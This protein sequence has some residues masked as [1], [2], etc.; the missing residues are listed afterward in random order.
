MAQPQNTNSVSLHNNNKAIQ[1]KKL[2]ESL[3]MELNNLP[4]EEE[5]GNIEYK[6][7]LINP[8]SSRL[9]HLVTQMKW[10]LQE[11]Q[12]EAIYKI[13]VEDNGICSGL[14]DSELEST[15][16]TL[17]SMSEKIGAD[18]T[19]LRKREVNSEAL[20]IRKQ[21]AEILV[22]KVPDDQ[23]F[24]DIRI[25]VLGNAD[26]GKSTLLGVL[27]HGEHD[28]GRG[29][30]RLNLFR[31]LHEIQ[32]GRTSC[33]SHE[34]L[35]FDSKGNVINYSESRTAEEICSA[36][37][38]IITFIDLAGHH[39][40]LKTT[41]FGL[42]SHHPDFAVVVVSA[43]RGVAGTTREH[44]GLAMALGVPIIAVVTKMDLCPTSV[45]DRACR[46]LE[47]L[48]TSAVCSK[49]PFRVRSEDDA[50]SAAAAMAGENNKVVPVFTVSS[51]TG[52][53]LSLL[54]TFFNVLMP[55]KNV[56][57]QEKLMQKPAEFQVDEVFTVP[58]VGAVV[59]GTLYH[60]TLAEKD[61]LL[62]GPTTEGRYLPV[63]VTTI[64]R[65]RAPCRIVR[66]GQAASLSLDEVDKDDI[67]KGMVIVSERLEPSCCLRF[68]AT[69]YLLYHPTSA[70]SVGFQCTVHAG[71][72]RQTAVV[73][74]I[75]NEEESLR[76]NEQACITFRFVCSP[77][78]I[79]TGS[80]LIFRERSTK[81][82]GQVTKVMPFSSS[83]F[84]QPRHK[85]RRRFASSGSLSSPTS[86][87]SNS[88][89]SPTQSRPFSP[90]RQHLE[91]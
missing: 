87:S 15:M 72:V 30:A 4:P 42:T 46:Q 54:T 60:G 24:L 85:H 49:I 18:L 34:I 73:E 71:N 7:K 25:S 67:R 79:R 36:A 43:N 48:L 50:Y 57:E 89:D 70:L 17:K 23:Q 19:T 81:G 64:Q 55:Q 86:S 58:E 10:R 69:A 90:K 56:R 80:T 22:R 66:A 52:K 1:D 35:G 84:C 13:G 29:R 38:K 33:I 26:A 62:I 14:T 51:V 28:N 68:E 2:K 53:N 78:Y 21:V 20:G 9:E 3:K 16:N 91:R 65:N 63:R 74:S 41:I 6:L 37:S 12:G 40:Y 32:S 45:S 83:D 76:L 31:H 11:G 61:S 82:I 8:T 59:G 39:K 77:E 5:E 44:L 88:D 47:Q 27:T 75:A